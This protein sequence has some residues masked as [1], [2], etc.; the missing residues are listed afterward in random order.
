[1]RLGLLFPLRSLR[2]KLLWGTVLV[3]A[4]VMAGVM[5]VVEYRLRATIIE[6]VERRGES[7]TRSLAASSYGHLLLYNFTALEQN[8]ARAA[9]EIDVL[10]ALVLDAEG[11]VAADSRRPERVGVVPEGPVA[12]RAAQAEVP[13]TQHITFRDT[14]ENAYDFAVPVRVNRDRW[15]TVRI[16][17]SKR[18]M[19][20]DIRETHRELVFVTV[21]AVLLGSVAAAVI[22]RR[23]A[24]PMQQLTEGA[25]AISRGDLNQRIEVPA[26]DEIGHLAK[27]FNHMAVQLFEQRTQIEEAHGQLRRRFQELADLKSYTDSVLASLTTGI[28][29]VD[30]EGRVVT[31]NP[32]AELLTG[33]FA[34]EVAGRY[35]TEV[36]SL[37]AGL[38]EI[39]METLASRSPISSLP[40]T[41]RR[42]NGSSVPVDLSTAPL[43]GADGKDLGVVGAFRDLSLVRELEHQL[44]RSDRLAALG[45]L[46]AGLAHE[47]K[48]PLTSLLTFSRHLPRRFDDEQFRE[49]FQ[50]VVPRELE[51]I[52][53]IV[54]RLLELS[55]PFRPS[56]SLVR[57]PRLLDRAAELYAN[58][59]EAKRIVVR[60]E[61]ASDVPPLRADEDALYRALVNLVANA[62][63][64]MGDG[65]RLT[66]RVEW[67]DGA[68]AL[69]TRRRLLNRRA[70]IEIEDTGAGIS[71]SEADR[72]F[73]P[74]FTTKEGG[75]GLGLALTHK[76]VEDHGGI[77]SFR[78]SPATG[79][80]FRVLLPLVPEMPFEPGDVGTR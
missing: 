9:A 68:E 74:F 15:G 53:E 60:R 50:N 25:A 65:G 47:I 76:I 3:I 31:L 7:L 70:R 54:E 78:S 35:C 32:E 5:A 11:R 44:R 38:G 56:F 51:R 67:D 8:V 57:L 59:I 29:T 37:T 48:N 1:M 19:E 30:L 34:G 13:L 49:K 80:T 77:I 40:L 21:A 62:L 23:I 24:G 66:L 2:M 69:A 17:L 39:F 36:F 42:R 61:Y 46:A 52:N 64:A 26:E 41:L 55:R 72:I 12:S 45:T 6:E 27:A 79:T 16:G 20:A 71:A 28:V 73:N 4:I 10:Y 63:E 58:V 33:F 43:K 75:T 22:A 18:R 14:G